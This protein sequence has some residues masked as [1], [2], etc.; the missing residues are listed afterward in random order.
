M[1]LTDRMSG[2][3]LI[4]G[5]VGV[6]LTLGL[7]PS[8]R[9]IIDPTTYMA[10][11]R[12]LMEVHSIALLS[13]PLWFLGAHGL[14]RRLAAAGHAAIVPLTFYGFGMAAMLS[15][16]ICDGLV[17]PGL[18][19]QIV[20]TSPN[21]SQGW[22]IAFNANE[23]VAITFVHVF[24][25][26]SSL[27]IIFWSIMIARKGALARGLGYFGLVVGVGTV[28]AVLAGY[29]DQHEHAFVMSILLQAAW[30]V[31]VGGV[32]LGLQKSEVRLQK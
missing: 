5:S 23:L 19:R 25:V 8:G 18:A 9:G 14:S 6:L 21:T 4:V 16:V 10:V 17:M 12:R 24:L 32:M 31:S 22:R 27:A 28:V 26:A 15:G 1:N 13:L 7:H 11:T 3:A 29:L 20:N 30:L 2:L